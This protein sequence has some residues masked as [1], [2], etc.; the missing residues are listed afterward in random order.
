MK[1]ETIK[2]LLDNHGVPY[3]VRDGR[4][5]ADSMESGRRVFEKTEDVTDWTMY[6][7]LCWL[8]Y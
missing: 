2:K 8:G 1:P 3:T 7:L 4:I 5:L 6:Q